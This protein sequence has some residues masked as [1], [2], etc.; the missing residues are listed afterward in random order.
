MLWFVITF[1]KKK[2]QYE[3]NPHDDE[4]ITEIICLHFRLNKYITARDNVS[5]EI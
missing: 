4:G 3:G 5:R 1:F 2:R